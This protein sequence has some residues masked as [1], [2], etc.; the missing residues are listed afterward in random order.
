M[1]KNE[2][3]N[4]KQKKMEENNFKF[5]IGNPLLIENYKQK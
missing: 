3:N 1:N 4:C 2:E 5:K